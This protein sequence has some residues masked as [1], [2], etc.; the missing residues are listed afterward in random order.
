M[1][2]ASSV[3]IVLGVAVMVTTGVISLSRSLKAAR[4]EKEIDKME[5]ETGLLKAEKY[6][7]LE[8]KHKKDM[9]N[10]R[11]ALIASTIVTVTA[12]ATRK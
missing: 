3:I 8:A 4:E 11:I 2:N 7:Q 6:D 10:I 9:K 12:I 1:K 5:D